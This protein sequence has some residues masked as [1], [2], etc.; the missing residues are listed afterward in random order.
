MLTENNAGFT[1]LE[2]LVGLFIVMISML[3]LLASINLAIGSNLNNEM[4]QQATTL[5][6]DTLNEVHNLPFDNITGQWT[7]GKPHSLY[8]RG[9][10][11]QYLVTKVIT[12]YSNS[13]RIQVGISW[14]YKGINYEHTVATMVTRP[15]GT[16]E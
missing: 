9:T 7:G 4:R 3:A 1:L 15:I 16:T 14:T 12:P 5:G 13:K 10:Q 8:L 6:E 2:L 11:R